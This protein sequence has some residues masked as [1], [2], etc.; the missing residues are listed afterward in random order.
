[1]SQYD[2]GPAVVHVVRLTITLRALHSEVVIE[3]DGNNGLSKASLEP[4]RRSR[5]RLGD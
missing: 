4:P 2:A 5:T 1:M 3:P